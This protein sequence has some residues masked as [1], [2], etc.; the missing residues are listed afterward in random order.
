MPD[1]GNE[2]LRI[3]RQLS[4]KHQADLLAS[5]KL[6]YAA[7]NS[8]RKASGFDVPA[9]CVSSPKPQEYSCENLLQ[10]SEK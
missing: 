8:A 5:V 3:S 1:K 10:R 4:P 7:E 2:V 9:A 6:A